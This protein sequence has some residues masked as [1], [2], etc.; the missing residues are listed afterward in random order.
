MSSIFDVK[1]DK[2]KYQ[3]LY[4]TNYKIFNNRGFFTAAVVIILLSIK[5]RDRLNRKRNVKERKEKSRQRFK[6]KNR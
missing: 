2:G 1:I 3:F 4:N 5:I 6:K